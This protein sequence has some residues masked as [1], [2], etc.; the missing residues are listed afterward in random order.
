MVTT[1]AGRGPRA[2]SG[3]RVVRRPSPPELLRWTRWCDVFYQANVSLRGLWPLLLVRR[4]WVVSHHS[5]YRRPDG[6]IAWQDRLK[7]WLLRCAAASIAVSQAVADDLATPSVV[8]PNP[9]R[10]DLFR[11]AAGGRADGRPG[12]PRA[13][14]SRTRGWTS[15]ST[16]WRCSRRRRSAPRLTIVGD[17]PER[18]GCEEQ[19]A[20]LG[21]AGQARLPGHPHGGGAGG[22]PQP[23]PDPGRPFA[24]RRAVRHRGPGGDR[25]RLRGRGLGGGRPQGGHRPL[26]RDLPQRRR[27]RTS[28]RVLGRALRH[29]ELDDGAAARTP[30]STS[31]ATPSRA[32]AAAYL[33]VIE[34]AARRS[35][36]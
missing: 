2:D 5:W 21:L 10:D 11:R 29:P 20:R 13:G 12:L 31:P 18:R 35:A 36:A 34:R 26:R 15:C 16:P 22:D 30:A 17:G 25:L 32:V 19:A 33:R 24:L 7:R 9:Y 6:R 4:P 8:I 3:Y 27:R 28:P 23:P 14:W 1:T